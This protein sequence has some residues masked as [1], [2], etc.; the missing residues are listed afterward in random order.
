MMTRLW[1]SAARVQQRQLFVDRMVQRV[2][3]R[4]F[5]I[6]ELCWAGTY[7]ADKAGRRRVPDDGGPIGCQ[8]TGFRMHRHRLFSQPFEVCEDC[9]GTGLAFETGGQG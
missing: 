7:G 9:G 5:A 3:G 1:L 4:E 6:S 8:G 2:G